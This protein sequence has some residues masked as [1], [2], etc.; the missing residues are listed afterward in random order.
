M[1]IFVAKLNFDTDNDTLRSAFEAFGEVTSAKV[2]TDF[3]TGRS[4]GFGFVEMSND[5]EARAAIE[6]LDNTDLDGRTIAVK[7]AR[8]KEDRPRNNSFR[9]FDNRGG[10]SGGGSNDRRGGGGFGY[11]GDRDRRGGWND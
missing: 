4:K 6:Q 9:K 1:N 5:D 2:V 3:N 7:E 10:G 8:P 11:G